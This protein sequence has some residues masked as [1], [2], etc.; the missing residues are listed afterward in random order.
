MVYCILYPYHHPKS[1]IKICGTWAFFVYIKINPQ[2]QSENEIDSGSTGATAAGRAGAAAAAAAVWAEKGLERGLK[3]ATDAALAAAEAA[4]AAISN[5]ELSKDSRPP[6][7]SLDTSDAV[8]VAVNKVP[9]PP[10]PK[11]QVVEWNEVEDDPRFF[12]VF[13]TDCSKYQNWQSLAIFFSADQVKQPGT[14]IRIASGCTQAQQDEIQ[15]KYDA[16]KNPRFQVHVHKIQ[17]VS[18]TKIIWTTHQ[19]Q[20]QNFTHSI[21]IN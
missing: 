12:L 10:P 6:K 18:C 5:A 4:E 3:V 7:G 9:P 13:S 14:I 8:K 19:Q 20:K 15:A 1:K 17:D 16:L 11:N 2:A 21:S